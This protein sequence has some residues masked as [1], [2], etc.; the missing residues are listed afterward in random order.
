METDHKSKPFSAVQVQYDIIS[1]H[2][3][4]FCGAIKH[5]SHFGGSLA[6]SDNRKIWSIYLYQTSGGGS[7]SFKI[8]SLQ[9]TSL[10]FSDTLFQNICFSSSSAQSYK[11]EILPALIDSWVIG[12]ALH[13]RDQQ[14]CN[15]RSF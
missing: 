2:A 9:Y 6:H 4:T 12:A 10:W 1:E 7:L 15:I 5:N 8:T 13:S 11:S 14:C 3:I